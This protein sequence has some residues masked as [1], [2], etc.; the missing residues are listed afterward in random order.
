VAVTR[1]DFLR[2]GLVAG[3]AIFVPRFGRWF[4]QGSGLLLRAGPEFQVDWVAWD[5]SVEADVSA[6]LAAYGE[7]LSWTVVKIDRQRKILTLDLRATD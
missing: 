7:P 2:A 6:L 1:R 3:G 4:R 5:R